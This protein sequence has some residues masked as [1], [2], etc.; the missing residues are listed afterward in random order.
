[1]K[2]HHILL[3]LI[4]PALLSACRVPFAPI[5]STPTVTPSST[6]TLPP[7]LT[8]T[9]TL[10]QVP[11]RTRPPTETPTASRTL[12]PTQTVTPTVTSI[13]PVS[14]ETPLPNPGFAEITTENAAQLSMV[15]QLVQPSIWQTAISRDG[16]Q[17]FF[18]T[19][20]G[21]YV[22]DRQGKQMAYWPSIM[23]PS[24]P[25]ETCLSINTDGTRFAVM[26]HREGKWLAQVYN[27]FDNN[28]NLLLEKPVEAAF[29]NIPN[30]VSIALSPDG[31]LLAYGSA[32][33]DTILTDMNSSQVLLTHPGGVASAAFSPDGVY[34]VVRRARQ[35]LLWKTPTWKNPIN[36][37]LPSDDAS[38][39]FSADGKRLA[40]A[41]TDKI[42]GYRLDTLNLNRE[43]PIVTPKDLQRSWQI[44]FVDQNILAGYATRWNTDHTK[45]TVDVGQ[46]NLETG[47]TLQFG[48]HET[49]TPDGLSA[50]WGVKV[51][52]TPPLAGPVMLSDQYDKFRFIDADQLQ[53][54]SSHSVCWVKLVGGE[55]TCYNDLRYRVLS[56][57]TQAFREVRTDRTTILQAWSGQITAQLEQPYPFLAITRDGLYRLVNV[58]DA[59]T[60]L[61]SGKNTLVNSF[62]GTLINYAENDN[63]IFLS[64]KQKT[65]SMIV[66]MIDKH[67]LLTTYLKPADFLLKPLVLTGDNRVYFV[68]NNVAGQSG[69]VLKVLDANGFA[70]DIA[71]VALPI[72]P[73]VMSMAANGVFAFGMKDGSVSIVSAN[74]LQLANFQASYTP[75]SG[76]ALSADDHY[77]AVASADGIRVFA[78]FP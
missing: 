57:E 48:S 41:S 39:T 46:W 73:E 1:M 37:L 2:I 53:I 36:L 75:I 50:L 19:N 16:K 29:R 20:Q 63:K 45:A 8:V 40:I 56:S 52:S 31:L 24:Q 13:Y 9:I 32:D 14:L 59:T 23:L 15:F 12:R 49:D 18:A 74:G 34:F 35:M 76:I 66:T 26:T 55:T 3:I 61:Y 70:S 10:T 78:V 27:V 54:N 71:T 67:T 65:S 33:G 5:T 25:C 44:A 42:T 43:I 7:T 72:E 62:P 22:Y 69:V 64:L 58:K 30:E 28:A 77:L 68:Q 17:L 60:D 47:E 51:L 21:I 11:S 38:Y 4:L 6:S